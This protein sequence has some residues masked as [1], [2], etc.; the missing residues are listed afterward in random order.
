M[1]NKIAAFAALMLAATAV[2]LYLV[3]ENKMPRPKVYFT[4]DISSAGL[5]RAYDA[6]GRGPF[7]RA[8]VDAIYASADPGKE[9]LIERIES[10]K[11]AHI[12]NAAEKLG[13]GSQKYEIIDLDKK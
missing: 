8:S 5:V 12:L 3:M 10:R 1:K 6:L 9:S 4:R 11:G 13:L 7:D 2:A